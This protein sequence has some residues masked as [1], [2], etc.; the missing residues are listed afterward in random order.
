MARPSFRDARRVSLDFESLSS[1][2]QW[3]SGLFHRVD[4]ASTGPPTDEITRLDPVS[5]PSPNVDEKLYVPTVSGVLVWS[6]S[7]RTLLTIEG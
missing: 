2:D 1:D 3:H 5:W 6:I 4:V 7:V